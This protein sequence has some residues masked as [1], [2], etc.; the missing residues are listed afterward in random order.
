MLQCPDADLWYIF[1]G[2]QTWRGKAEQVEKRATKILE[3]SPLQEMAR[4]SGIFAQR[5]DLIEM[6]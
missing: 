2:L 5:E 3:H 1:S 6:Y 4:L